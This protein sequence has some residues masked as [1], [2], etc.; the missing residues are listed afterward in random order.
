MMCRWAQELLGYHFSILHRAARMMIHVDGL[1]CHFGSIITQHLCVEAILHKVERLTA[2]IRDIID[3][4]E[5]THITPTK[6]AELY[7][8]PILKSSVIAS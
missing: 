4:P 7:S 1:S 8:I 5:A 2:Y 6:E 3:I